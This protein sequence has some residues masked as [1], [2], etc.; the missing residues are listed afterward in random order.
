[1]SCGKKVVLL[2]RY[3]CW[4][5]PTNNDILGAKDIM[6]EFCVLLGADANKEECHRRLIEELDNR[7]KMLYILSKKSVL[8]HC[9]YFYMML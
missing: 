4:H 3:A 1:M 5:M 9:F 8:E 6:D 7:R 2:R